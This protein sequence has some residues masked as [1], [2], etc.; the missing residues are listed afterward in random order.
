M[1]STVSQ[2]ISRFLRYALHFPNDLLWFVSFKVLRFF[3]IFNLCVNLLTDI[4]MSDTE[5]IIPQRYFIP[6]TCFLSFNFFAMVGNLLPGLYTWV[7][8][9]H[10][11]PEFL[12]WFL[13]YFYH[14]SLDLSGCGF[15]F[16]CD[17]CLFPSSCFVITSHS[18]L[19]ERY[20]FLLTMIGYI[21]LEESS[22]AL[23][24]DTILHW[25]WCTALARSNLNMQR[26]LACLVPLVW[27][28]ASSVASTFR[29]LCPS[30]SNRFLSN[31]F[32]FIIFLFRKESSL[33]LLTLCS[34]FIMLLLFFVL[35]VLFCSYS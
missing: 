25:R 23:L 4:K 15:R 29:W 30:W 24:V 6:V 22:W 3:K 1:C 5:F 16:C 35:F 11:N 12:N 13:F 32:S 14:V 10:V 31:R 26:Q 9:N 33:E 34:L 8:L 2:R 17:S 20:P 27:S 28:P 7:K 19:K 18:V 21:G